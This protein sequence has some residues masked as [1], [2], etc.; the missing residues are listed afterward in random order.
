MAQ[1]PETETLAASEARRRWSQ[2]LNRV[3]RKETRVIVE[4][5][6]VAVAALISAEDLERLR[7]WEAER[8]ERFRA[9]EESWRAF[10]D[11]PAE[12]VERE[13]ALAV[14]Q[15][16]EERRRTRRFTERS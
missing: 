1:T 4:K 7:Q 15:V 8:A 16:R 2:L 11:A 6:G 5:S 14:E 12:E 13:V 10:E 9:L 3:F